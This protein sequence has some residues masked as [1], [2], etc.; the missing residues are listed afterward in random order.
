MAIRTANNQSLTE[1]TAFPSAVAL[2][3]L[4]LLETITASGDATISFTSGIDS[5]YKEYIFKFYD[6]NPADDDKKLQFNLSVDSG[7]NYNVA[8]TTTWFV[9]YHDEADTATRL[10]YLPVSSDLAQGTGAQYFTESIGNGAD[11]SAAGELHLFSPSSTTFVKHFYSRTSTYYTSDYAMDTFV[12]GYGNTTSAVDAI[13]FSEE[14]GGN[15]DG[16][17]KMYGVT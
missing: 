3:G 11:E 6:L 14:S 5:T 8:K 10:A 7:D 17:I 15:F 12:A 9:A 16:T 4:V 1:I 2:G 13:Q